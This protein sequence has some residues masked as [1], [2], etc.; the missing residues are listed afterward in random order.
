MNF[1]HNELMKEVTDMGIKDA[2]VRR[3]KQ[4]CDER[5]MCLNALANISGVS[6]ST[7]YSMMKS[8]RQ[9]ISLLTVKKFC[10]GLD[11]SLGEFFSSPIFDELEQEIY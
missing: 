9:D 6:P 2:T 11:I 7:A 3:F 4:I 8:E 10:D 5:N 1:L